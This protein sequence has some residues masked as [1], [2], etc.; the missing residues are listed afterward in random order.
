MAADPLVMT[1]HWVGVFGYPGVFQET[2]FQAKITENCGHI[3]GEVSE[4][5]R[6][7]FLTARL[8]GSRSGSTVSFLKL[9][10]ISNE[11]YDDIAYEGTLSVDGRQLSGT[12]IIHG[13]WSG[14]FVMT[15]ANRSS[16]SVAIEETVKTSR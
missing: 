3:S 5:E 7:Q 8:N 12:W 1:G 16:Q 13:N 14:D 10:D 11:E 4:T 2:A 6:G 9:Y 15:R